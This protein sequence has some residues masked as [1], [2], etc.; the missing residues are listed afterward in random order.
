MA[1]YLN[2]YAKGLK[3]MPTPSDSGVVAIRLNITVPAMAANDVLALGFLPAGCVPVDVALD[4]DDLDTGST[5]VVS[6]GILN[7]A[8][9]AISGT[10]WMSGVN[11]QSPGFSRRTT[12]AVDRVAV[13]NVNDRPVGVVFTGAGTG[14]GELGMTI[15]YRPA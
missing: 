7:S 3:P 11:V 2:D 12:N 6:A 5:A 13:D 8:L 1:T 9:T 4:Y 15:W 14:N 10:A